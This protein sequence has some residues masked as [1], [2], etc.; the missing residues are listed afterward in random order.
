MI[1]KLSF[2]FSS[3]KLKRMEKTKPILVASVALLVIALVIV[4]FSQNTVNRMIGSLGFIGSPNNP[5]NLGFYTD[6]S[7]SQ[8]LTSFDWGTSSPGQ[9]V[10][11]T[12]YAYNLGSLSINDLSMN[13]SNW[14]PLEAAQYLP[15]SWNYTHQVIAV[16]E[17]LFIQ[18][19]LHVSTSIQGIRVFSFNINV[20]AN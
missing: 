8:N 10:A 9:N 4:A 6:A 14:N 19:L 1:R 16:G 12:A 18:F 11:R 17:G 20:Y 13:C 15:L 7:R 3:E 5:L 2:Y